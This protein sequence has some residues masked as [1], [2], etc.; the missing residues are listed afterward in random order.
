MTLSK[1]LGIPRGLP[2][3]RK[4]KYVPVETVQE[5]GHT[6]VSFIPPAAVKLTP[7]DINL[8]WWALYA[9]ARK[10]NCHR[11]PERLSDGMA[12]RV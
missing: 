8:I 12:Y 10:I 11:E 2:M 3:T 7:E 1:H 9:A 6:L 5:N 4:T